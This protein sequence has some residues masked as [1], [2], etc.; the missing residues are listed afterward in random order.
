MG[1]AAGVIGGVAGAV[2]GGIIGGPTGAQLGYM[3]G[4]ALG[5]SLFGPTTQVTGPRLG[6]LRVTSSTQGDTLPLVYGRQRI[7]GKLIWA[8][9]LEEVTTTQSQGGKGGPKQESTTYSYF[10]TAAYALCQGPISGIQ[11]IWINSELVYDISAPTIDPAVAPLSAFD[12]FTHN[13]SQAD[14]ARKSSAQKM[15]SAFGVGQYMRLYLGSESQ[16]PD[17]RMEA[18][19]GSGKTP[20]LRGTAYLVFERL[21]LADYGNRLP[22]VEVEVLGLGVTGAASYASI[23]TYF[24]RETVSTGLQGT[25][26]QIHYANGELYGFVPSPLQST[27]LLYRWL[28][29]DDAP[30][31]WT[32]AS[33]YEPYQ[34]ICTDQEVIIGSGPVRSRSGNQTP[35]QAMLVYIDPIGGGTR[36]AKIAYVTERG[37]PSSFDLPTVITA[38]R[39][40]FAIKGGTYALSCAPYIANALGCNVFYKTA[41]ATGTL[42]VG[43]D[44]GAVADIAVDGQTLYAFCVIGSSMG[45][46]AQMC[47]RKFDLSSQT[48]I[49]TSPTL[50]LRGSGDL[51][52]T[53]CLNSGS[54]YVSGPGLYPSGGAVTDLGALYKCNGSAPFTLLSTFALSWNSWSLFSASSA[55]QRGSLYCDGTFAI[56]DAVSTGYSS[57]AD[58]RSAAAYVSLGDPSADPANPLSSNVALVVQD[59]CNRSGLTSVDVSALTGDKIVGYTVASRTSARSAID[60]LRQY[61]FFDGAE[62]DG[63]VVFTKRGGAAVRTIP[64]EDLLEETM[65]LVRAPELELPREVCIRFYDVNSDFQTGAQYARRIVTQANQASDVSLAIAMTAQRAASVAQAGLYEAWTSRITGSFSTTLAHA[66]VEPGDVVMVGG[67]RIRI[68]RKDDNGGILQFEGVLDDASAIIQSVNTVDSGYSTSTLSYLGNTD[69]QLFDGPALTDATV[70]SLYAMASGNGSAWRGAAIFDSLDGVDYSSKTSVLV[71][72]TQGTTASAITAQ[73]ARMIDER[74][75]LDV[76]LR[77]GGTLSGCSYTQL[78]KGTNSALVG[79]ELVSFRDAELIGGTVE[80]PTYRIRGLLR[81]R[82]GSI[83]SAHATGERF[84]LLDVVAA[85]PYTAADIGRTHY[86]KAISYGKSDGVAQAVA[87]SDIGYKPNAVAQLNAGRLADGSAVLQWIRSSRLDQQWRDSGGGALDETTES[88]QIDIYT[89]GGV[90]KRTLTSTVPTVTYAAA[91]RATDGLTSTQFVATVYQ[92][93]DRVGRGRPASITTPAGV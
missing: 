49:Y 20:A 80:N 89:T 52:A 22:N 27:G 24:P 67:H 42:N 23:C 76:T 5:G 93:S 39:M 84:V 53:M 16:A 48:L 63:Q 72:E 85:L 44:I 10:G 29:G 66:V 38:D 21:P 6:E 50:T 7:A 73:D 83:V 3:A 68:T 82:R 86:L 75:V 12:V 46:N 79:N 74:S 11:R 45:L 1:Q 59:L 69:L 88:Y 32:P 81:G 58:Q 87:P 33:T 35:A 43:S 92:I 9:P 40:T 37:V 17:S 2:V 91:D 14:L 34:P 51:T 41:S 8:L 61:A 18:E 78:L 65:T 15:K 13:G 77:N 25:S 47:V 56:I 55:H 28:P 19:I 31:L 90:F 71:S 4:S 26:V 36:K 60:P 57:G 64:D 62:I 54:I 30:T 70:G